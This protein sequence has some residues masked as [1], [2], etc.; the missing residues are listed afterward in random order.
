MVQYYGTDGCGK[1]GKLDKTRKQN[2][3]AAGGKQTP[4]REE[5][6]KKIGW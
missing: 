6:V 2:Q 5:N 4:K 3:P 1:N